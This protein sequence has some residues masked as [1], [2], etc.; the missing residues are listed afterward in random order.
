MVRQGRGA[1]RP[2]VPWKRLSKGD[3]RGVVSA[4]TDQIADTEETTRPVEGE[5]GWYSI[6]VSGEIT[7]DEGHILLAVIPYSVREPI[8][9]EYGLVP[10]RDYHWDPGM[11][12]E[13]RVAGAARGRKNNEEVEVFVYD[14]Y[15]VDGGMLQ[16]TVRRDII[17]TKRTGARVL[18]GYFSPR[19]VKKIKFSHVDRRPLWRVTIKSPEDFRR[20]KGRKA[21]KFTVGDILIL[22]S[23]HSRGILPPSEV[24]YR[25]L[26][27]GKAIVVLD[28][29]Q[30]SVPLEWLSKK[31]GTRAKGRKHNKR[32]SRCISGKVTGE[33]WPQRQAVAACLSMDRDKRLRADGSYRSAGGRRAD[34]PYPPVSE[35]VGEAY[36][37]IKPNHY[38]L[39]APYGKF[40]M[41]ATVHKAGVLGW[42][43]GIRLNGKRIGYGHLPTQSRAFARVEDIL[44]YD[45]RGGT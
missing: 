3:Q 22:D 15:G 24:N 13:F 19:S 10:R 32:V 41:R 40:M 9:R 2:R 12:A 6:D 42:G 38:V 16:A 7:M 27:Q 8:L 39:E 29:M 23:P 44:R 21:T 25:G 33:G 26:H 35:V 5:H 43:W 1:P 28:G 36:T 37:Q 31:K 45:P 11:E 4:Y 17:A 18:E 30:R 14:V 20:K 34:V